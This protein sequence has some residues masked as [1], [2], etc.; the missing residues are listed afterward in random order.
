MKI[1]KWLWIKHIRAHHKINALV[2]DTSDYQFS[3]LS[4]QVQEA[5]LECFSYLT[6]QSRFNPSNPEIC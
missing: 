1:E 5:L 6:L 4:R 3:F 2:I